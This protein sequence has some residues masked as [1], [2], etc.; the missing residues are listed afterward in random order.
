MHYNLQIK[1]KIEYKI[2]AFVHSLLKLWVAKGAIFVIV[3]FFQNV[4]NDTINLNF[5]QML[6]LVK[7]QAINCLPN[8]IF[9]NEAVIVKIVNLKGISR[10]DTSRRMLT[11]KSKRIIEILAY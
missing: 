7:N 10:L 3:T 5:G 2:R 6:V 11:V 8:V 4:V 9:A 1:L